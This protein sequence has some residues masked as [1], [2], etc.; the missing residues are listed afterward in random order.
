MF[1][2]RI[3][4][5]RFGTGVSPHLL[6][7]PDLADM[8]RRLH[9]PD[10][11][12]AAY[13]GLGSVALRQVRYKGWLAK[14]QSKKVKGTAKEG[15][16]RSIYFASAKRM[17]KINYAYLQQF[18]QRAAQ[19]EDGFRERLVLFW[20]DHFAARVK[21]SN[22]DALTPAFVD[23]AI[24]PHLTGRFADM[25]FAVMTDPVMLNF[26]DQDESVGPNSMVGMDTGQGLNENLAR[27]VMELHTL[28]VG[29][30]YSQRDVEQLAELL[31]GLSATVKS[32]FAWRPDMAE[33]EAETVLGRVYGEAAPTL[34][35]I[36]QVLEDLAI[37]PATGPHLARKLAIHFISPEPDEDMVARGAEA[38]RDSGG[39]LGPVYEALLSHPAAWDPAPHK[40]R[41]PQ[42]FLFAALRGLG[43]APDRLAALNSYGIRRVLQFPLAAM[44]Q[45][46]LHPDEP[47]GWPEDNVHWLSPNNQAVRIEW[48]AQAPSLLTP[49]LPDPRDFARLISG[50]D[51]E[52]GLKTA[53]ER[54]ETQALGLMMTLVSPAFQRR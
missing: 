36:R 21:G 43:V 48:A 5:R 4:E 49:D 39:M 16:L 27:E 41:Q 13:P 8:L 51:P 38:Y 3:A 25:L 10:R 24:R 50:G 7:P 20:T 53:V 33:P 17:R 15:D 6:P 30:T 46:F 23:D 52:P 45:P 40:I 42:D 9:G 29:A 54:A 44:G 34:D 22:T 1:D 47:N 37:H 19:T 31:T 2:P 28:G 12:A 18:A 14:Q 35:D 11:M 32:G 26:L